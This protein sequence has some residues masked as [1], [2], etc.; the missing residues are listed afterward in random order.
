MVH[1]R[2]TEDAEKF[3]SFICPD[4][5]S[6]QMK[7][8]SLTGAT[9]FDRKD[10]RTRTPLQYKWTV[11]YDRYISAEGGRATCPFA[12]PA[13]QCQALAGK[14]PAN[15]QKFSSPCTPWLCGE[16][17]R[18]FTKPETVGNRTRRRADR[19]KRHEWSETSKTTVTLLYHAWMKP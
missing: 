11:R 4:E 12:V 14:S 6:G 2:A 3:T 15:G 16:Y 17:V 13:R 7:G 19:T 8:L 10:R 1:H 18:V 9:D 5:A